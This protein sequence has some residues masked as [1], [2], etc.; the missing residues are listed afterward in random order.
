MIN[1]VPMSGDDYDSH[2]DYS[3]DEHTINAVEGL[4]EMSDSVYNAIMEEAVH[5]KERSRKRRE[6]AARKQKIIDNQ[7]RE[8]EREDAERREYE[9]LKAKFESK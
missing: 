1:G 7:R 3:E 2:V 6:E 5:A 9:K 8:K 4:Q